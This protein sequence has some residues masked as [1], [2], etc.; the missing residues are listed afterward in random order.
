[1]QGDREAAT[2]LGSDAFRL[3]ESLGDQAGAAAA[4]TT[5][6][7]VAFTG[8]QDYAEARRLF[9]E[10]L[11]SLGEGRE[12]IALIWLANVASVE[13]DHNRAV[14]LQRELVAGAR[15][16]GSIFALATALN[17]LYVAQ[18]FA[19]DREGA[20]RSIEESVNL[21]REV[22]HK[23]ALANGLCNLGHVKLTTDPG[24]A[25]THYCESL[26]LALE[27]GNPHTTAYCLQGGA[28]VHAARG[29]HTTAAT[30]LGAAAR[31][32][33]LAGGRLDRSRQAEADALEEECRGALEPDAFTRAW[34]E[35]AALDVDAAT[36][37][38][39]ARWEA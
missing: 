27:I 1:M 37:F 17:N 6:G 16:D 13:G 33:A 24:E 7:I 4:L 2:R 32:A 26:R 9:E 11:P 29:D 18:A 15:R 3:F 14:E 31:A 19:G 28:A 8:R 25:L 30:L 35:G 36:A 23:T 39:L 12:R 38:A 34:D 21:L 5:L 10:A 20:T 22:G